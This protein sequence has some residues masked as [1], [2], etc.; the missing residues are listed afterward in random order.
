MT[1]ISQQW[2][3]DSLYL[4]VIFSYKIPRLELVAREL[5]FANV[6]NVSCLL[7]DM[8]VKN[9][10]EGNHEQNEAKINTGTG[11]GYV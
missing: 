5:I 8:Y 11:V 4:R 7:V 9:S 10:P 2:M 1:V 6:K 3:V